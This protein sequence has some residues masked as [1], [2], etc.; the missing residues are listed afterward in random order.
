MDGLVSI[1]LDKNGHGGMIGKKRSRNQVISFSNEDGNNE[2]GI[3]LNNNMQTE[4]KESVGGGKQA[5]S[6]STNNNNV[7]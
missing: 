2:S 6:T 5:A 7:R 4:S 1:N 3:S